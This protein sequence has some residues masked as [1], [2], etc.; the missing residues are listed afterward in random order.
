MSASSRRHD[1]LIPLS[2]EHQYGLMLCLRIHRGLLE[3]SADSKWLTSKA[4]NA[5]LFYEGE[6][7]THFKAEEDFLFPAMSELDGAARIIDELLAEHLEI[8]R[9]IDQLRRIE[10]LSLAATLKQL[11]DLLEAHIRKEEREL[12]PIYEEHA[13]T[14]MTARVERDIHG[15]IGSASQPRNPELLR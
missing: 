4:N 1:S 7:V 12:F 2:R 3:H 11:A 14:A 6:L 13:T 5:V 8:R 15:L 9:L 10:P